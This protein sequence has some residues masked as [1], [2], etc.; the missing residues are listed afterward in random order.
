MATSSEAAAIR[1]RR[2]HT[3]KNVDANVKAARQRALEHQKLIEELAKPL[4]AVSEKLADL[5]HEGD[6]VLAAGARRIESLK[7]GLEKKIEKLKADTAAKIEQTKKDTETK[8]EE[9]QNSQRES[10]DALLLEYAQAIVQF[11]HGGSNADLATVLGITQKKAKELVA[12]STTELK[13]AGIAA[14]QTTETAAAAKT[15]APSTKEPEAPAEDKDEAQVAPVDSPAL[16]S[17]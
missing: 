10:E 15:S 12:S 3:V 4:N 1:S 2:L 8:L 6:A 16:A 11:S 5:D 17:A 9:L 7:S 14:P 13:K